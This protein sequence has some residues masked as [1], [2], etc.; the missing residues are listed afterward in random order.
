MAR[1][2][3]LPDIF[4]AL[5]GSEPACAADPIDEYRDLAMLARAW[6]RIG[7]GG[8][9]GDDAGGILQVGTDRIPKED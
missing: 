2:T 9:T 7:S 1:H 3:L 5:E 8:V 6:E 4:T